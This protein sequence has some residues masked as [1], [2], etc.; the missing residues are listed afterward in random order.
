MRASEVFE[1]KRYRDDVFGGDFGRTSVFSDAFCGEMRSLSAVDALPPV[2]ARELEITLSQMNER[3]RTRCGAALLNFGHRS[4]PNQSL[5][6]TH[7]LVTD[8]AFARSAPSIR[9]ADL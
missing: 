8:R 7:M 1:S 2:R 9:V 5:Q 6:P 3:L 4:G